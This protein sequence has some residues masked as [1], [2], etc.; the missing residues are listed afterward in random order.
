MYLSSKDFQ[1][2]LNF[3]FLYFDK[4]ITYAAEGDVLLTIPYFNWTND[5]AEGDLFLIIP[6]L[7]ESTDQPDLP[8]GRTMYFLQFLY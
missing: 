8:I 7:I 2:I 1:I 3:I 5:Q 6:V 4:T